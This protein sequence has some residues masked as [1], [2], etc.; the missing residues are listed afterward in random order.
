MRDPPLGP[1]NP[2]MDVTPKIGE[3][4]SFVTTQFIKFT[5]AL[6]LNELKL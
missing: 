2:P 1:N 4:S 5:S 3:K 6:D